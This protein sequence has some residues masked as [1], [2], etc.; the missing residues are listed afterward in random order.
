MLP[1]RDTTPSKNI[2]IGTRSMILGNCVVFMFELMM[3]E[4]VLQAFFYYFGLVRAI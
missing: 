4:P 3:P 2:P 1:I